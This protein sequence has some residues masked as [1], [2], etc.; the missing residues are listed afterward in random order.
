MFS[1]V[2][3]DKYADQTQQ[4]SHGVRLFLTFS[5]V[6]LGE[7]WGVAAGQLGRASEGRRRQ[8]GQQRA[9]THLCR[10]ITK[11]KKGTISY[12]FKII[13]DA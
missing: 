10:P 5:P 8:I 6:E 11:Q 4:Q 12:V 13:L 1:L 7:A 3:F 9:V 2:C